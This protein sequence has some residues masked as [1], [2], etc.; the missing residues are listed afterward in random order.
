[1]RRGDV[2]REEVFFAEGVDEEVVGLFDKG[3][4]DF[5]VGKTPKVEVGL[6]ADD[7]GGLVSDD[8]VELLVFVEEC[9]DVDVFSLVFHDFGEVVEDVPVL[10]VRETA[11]DANGFYFVDV[12]D[13]LFARSGLEVADNALEVH[14][15][16]KIHHGYSNKECCLYNVKLCR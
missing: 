8:E 10:F 16:N 3:A 1:M 6:G 2:L 14:L 4:D 12:V 7:L 13:F 11:D 9:D 5:I 15:L